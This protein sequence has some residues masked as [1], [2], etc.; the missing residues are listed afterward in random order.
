MIQTRSTKCQYSPM[1]WKPW[2]PVMVKNVEPYSPPVT[3]DSLPCAT[4]SVTCEPAVK[5]A[6][7]KPSCT[8][9]QYSTP[10][11]DTNVAPSRMVASSQRDRPLRSPAE[12]AANALTID[13]DEQIRMNVLRPVSGTLRTTLG[14]AHSPGAPKRRITYAPIR[15]VKNITSDAKNTH[16]PSLLL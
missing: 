5:P 1:T 2:N 11:I 9:F 13:T 14:L 3:S 8:S 7:V 4:S 12:I 15:P 16:M 10:W 6:G